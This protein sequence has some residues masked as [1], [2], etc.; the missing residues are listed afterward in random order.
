MNLPPS[1][2]P[3]DRVARHLRDLPRSGIRDFFDLVSSRKDVISLGVGEPGFV[4]PWR[5]REAG[6]YALEHGATCYTS[7]LGLPALRQSI[8]SYLDRTYEFSYDPDQEIL[9]TVG[10]SEAIDLAFRA[11]LEP[12][13]EVLYQEPCYVSYSPVIQMAHG[14]PVAVPTR[15]EDGF[16]LTRE[17]LEARCTPRTKVL[18]INFPTNPTGATLNTHQAREIADFVKAHDLLLITD[19][20]YA[21]LT[22]DGPHRSV[23]SEPDMKERTIFLHGFSKSW[24]MTGFRLG[25]ACAPHALIE[26]MMK[27]HQYT[28][29]CAPILSQKAASEALDHAEEDVQKMR[30]AYTRHRNFM[31]HAFA[32]MGLD[33]LKPKGAFYAFPS[34]R[35]TGLTSRDFAMALLEEESVAVVPGSAFGPSGEGYIRCCFATQ[36]E[37]I[38][39]ACE[40]MRRMVIARL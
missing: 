33:C 9:V 5:I 15:A 27:I 6:M 25:F 11:V 12:G 30:E 37:D 36:L 10:V 14:V 7:N 29:L 18:M 34:I 35:G 8:A 38:K 2:S 17:A 20:V 32:E 28:M 22:Y 21:E 3:H 23:L 26:A 31:V 13:D 39:T 19:E 40:R 1:T 24:A 16:T 4:T